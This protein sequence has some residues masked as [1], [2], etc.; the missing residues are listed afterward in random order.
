MNSLDT[1]KQVVYIQLSLLVGMLV[2][3]GVSL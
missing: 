3:V 1:F 2:I